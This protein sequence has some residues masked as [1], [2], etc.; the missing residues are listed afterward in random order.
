MFYDLNVFINTSNFPK[1]KKNP[2]DKPLPEAV[3]IS[4]LPSNLSPTHG[5][6][7]STRG[8]SQYNPLRI[9][10][11]TDSFGKEKVRLATENPPS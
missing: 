1:N 8:E 7:T 2:K 3:T 10:G 9:L 4:L 5:Q 6:E 11:T